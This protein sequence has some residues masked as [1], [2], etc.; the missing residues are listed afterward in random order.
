MS[1]DFEE[2]LY[3]DSGLLVV[4]FAG[5]DQLQYQFARSL[6]AFRTSHV[7]M[8][9]TTQ[10]YHAVGVL[11]IGDRQDVLLYLRSFLHRGYT[12]RFVGVSSGAY[13]ALLYG[14]L[15]PA[16]ELVVFSALSGR[17]V[18]DFPPQWH[19]AIGPRPDYMD[20]LRQHFRH[21][22]IAKATA[23]ISDGDSTECDRQMAARVGITDIR[24]IP[25]YAHKDLARGMRDMGMLRELLT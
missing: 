21:G 2:H 12:L 14:Q 3:A 11:G 1:S 19:G 15:T 7:L 23:F 24:V 25:G 17:D 8:R 22:P 6:E 9:D 16:H 5:G 4:T 13:A 18:D 10:M 20:D